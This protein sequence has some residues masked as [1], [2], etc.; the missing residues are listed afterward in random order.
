[1]TATLAAGILAGPAGTQIITNGNL[2]AFFNQCSSGTAM[3]PSPHGAGCRPRDIR[4]SSS[5]SRR[6]ASS[7]ST[8]EPHGLEAFNVYVRQISKIADDVI[9][10]YFPDRPNSS[11]AQ[12]A[13]LL[14]V[15]GQAAGR[16]DQAR[17]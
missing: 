7:T 8:V 3:T 10:I 13:E 11:P 16:P 1:M 6:P 2:P 15:P 14:P 5:R 4:R 12:A 17:R 9:D